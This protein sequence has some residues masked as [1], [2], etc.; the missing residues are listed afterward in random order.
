M[1]ELVDLAEDAIGAFPEVA[2]SIHTIFDI[3]PRFVEI[4]AWVNQRT[5]MRFRVFDEDTSMRIVSAV[6]NKRFTEAFRYLDV[7]YEGIGYKMM[8]NS[9][10]YALDLEIYFH[11]SSPI[12]NLASEEASR[13]RG[14]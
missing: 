14:F 13:L 2:D 9:H 7:G 12:P 3:L 4:Q 11:P 1:S 8:T 5:I 10:A 6:P